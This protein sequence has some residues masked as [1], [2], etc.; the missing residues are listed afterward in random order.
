MGEVLK[1][2]E[3]V[4]LEFFQPKYKLDLENYDLSE[5]Q[6]KF[7]AHPLQ[8]LIPC[9]KE[10]GRDPILILSNG[11]PAGFFVLHGWEGVKEFYGN[12][13]ALLLRAYSVDS[14]FQGKGV[15]KQSLKMLPT[16]VKERYTG[17][18]EVILAV[19]F[20]NHVAQH[21]YKSSGFVDKGIRA[22]GR[23]GEMYILHLEL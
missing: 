9:E 19:N 15:A 17:I 23:M 10:E 20:S 18:N 8:A 16:F 3:T 7:T 6:M 13:Q 14:S 1:T 12:K 4:R 21:V 2:A 11:E 22:M 5:E